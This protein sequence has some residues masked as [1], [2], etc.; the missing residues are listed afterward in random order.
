MGPALRVPVNDRTG[1]SHGHPVE[2]PILD[3][4][5]NFADHFAG[6]HGGAGG[7]FARLFLPGRQQLDVGAA[8]VDDQNSWSFRCP[9]SF[10]SRCSKWLHEGMFFSPPSAREFQKAAEKVKI[11]T[12]MPRFRSA[13]Q[14]LS[15]KS[16][17]HSMVDAFHQQAPPQG[18]ILRKP[19]H[20]DRITH[21]G[22]TARRRTRCSAANMFYLPQVR[23]AYAE[24]L[25]REASPSLAIATRAAPQWLILW[26]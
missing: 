22:S 7:N 14:N 2:L 24:S 12:L 18:F 13:A 21:W 4:R 19:D 10:H 8:R 25:S 17:S 15:V 1:I 20:S 9:Y 5:F 3:A 6:R 26:R 23:L 16:F 11:I